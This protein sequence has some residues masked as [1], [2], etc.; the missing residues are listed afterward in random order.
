MF[1]EERLC[2]LLCLLAGDR[3][4]AEAGQQ[5]KDEPRNKEFVHRRR[6]KMEAGGRE[7]RPAGAQKT[8]AERDG[9]ARWSGTIGG[10]LYSASP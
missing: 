6:Q 3:G 7:I 5:R 2:D 4:G 9:V 10:N 8:G 1:L